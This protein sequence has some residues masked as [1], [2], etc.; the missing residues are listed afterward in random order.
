MLPVCQCL[1]GVSYV[2]SSFLSVYSGRSNLVPIV[3][4]RLEVEFSKSEFYF[5]L[6]LIF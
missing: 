2:L 3:P 5:I 1:K 4:T 6:I